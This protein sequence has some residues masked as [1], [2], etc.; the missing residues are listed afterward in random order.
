[1]RTNIELNQELIEEI[2]KLTSISTKK[3]VVNRALEEYLRKLKLT[4]LADL[5]GKVE[6]E[7]DLE[8]MR[9]ERN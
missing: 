1:M 2:M 4:E 6:W 7:G 3:E 9:S 5:A 8:E